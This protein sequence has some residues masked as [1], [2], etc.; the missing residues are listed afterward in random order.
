[1]FQPTTPVTG[2]VRTANGECRLMILKEYTVFVFTS[3]LQLI[4]LGDGT[5]IMCLFFSSLF[6]HMKL[7]VMLIY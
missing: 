5:A 7:A 2:Y 4:D 1:M 3:H 6:P